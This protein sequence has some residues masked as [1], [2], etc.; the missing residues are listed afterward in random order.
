[1][2]ESLPQD[3]V[4]KELKA[5]CNHFVNGGCTTLA[6]LKRDGHRAAMPITLIGCTE[7]RAVKEIERLREYEWMYKDLCK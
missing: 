3:E 7:Y 2:S 5:E 6:C 1:M 4:V